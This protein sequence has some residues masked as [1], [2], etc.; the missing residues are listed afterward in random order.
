MLDVWGGVVGA[1]RLQVVT[2]PQSG[3]DPL[4]LWRRFAEAAGV[5]PS[6]PSRRASGATRRSGYPSCELLRRINE[7]IGPEVPDDCGRLIRAVV[8]PD[9]EARAGTEARVRPDGPGLEVASAWNAK[10]AEAIRAAGVRVVGDLDQDLPTQPPADAAPVPPPTD[11]ELLE[12]AET[13]RASLAGL[14]ATPAADRAGRR[15]RGGPG[16]GDD[17]PLDRRRRPHRGPPGARPR[18]LG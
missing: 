3:G 1:D 16:A 14:G 17:D 13:V 10:A 11:D 18:P 9:L 5:D 6:V 15:G 2:V 12:A 4:L 7:A 8:A